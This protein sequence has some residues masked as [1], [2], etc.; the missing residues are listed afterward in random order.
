MRAR[1]DG[2]VGPQGFRRLALSLPGVD[3]LS[4]MGHPGMRVHGRI[5]ATL[6][7]PDAGHAMVKLT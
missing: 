7:S 6:G 2:N 4:H 1:R 3:E 5:L